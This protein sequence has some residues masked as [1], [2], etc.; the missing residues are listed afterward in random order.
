M[1]KEEHI[2]ATAKEIFFFK[3][4]LHA[5]TQEIADAAAVN[6]SL[7]NYYFRS[8]DHLFEIV[9][10]EAVETMSSQLDSVIYAKVP[11]ME[12][13]KLLMDVYMKEILKYPYKE[14]FLITEIC[15]KNVLLKEKR[16]SNAL[17]AFV[18]EVAQ[19]MEKGTIKKAD[20]VHFII[21][22]FSLMA[23]PVIMAPLYRKLFDLDKENYQALLNER[24][25]LVF[26]LLTE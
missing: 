23:Y 2:K 12:K 13:L 17:I 20:P 3:G 5:T 16:K 19:E 9:Y 11:F 10:N 22:L 6:R 21:N 14:S 4:N 26:K 25:A 24:K 1:N 15:C 8:R 7:I 18:K